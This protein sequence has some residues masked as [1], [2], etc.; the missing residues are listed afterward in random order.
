MLQVA[1]E[2]ENI[3]KLAAE[4]P[5]AQLGTIALPGLPTDPTGYL[6]GVRTVLTGA[7]RMADTWDAVIR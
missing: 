5:K 4:H 1:D 7:R 2:L 6:R 3:T